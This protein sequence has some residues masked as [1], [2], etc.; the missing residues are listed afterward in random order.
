[1]AGARQET[2]GRQGAFSGPGWPVE[3]TDAGW[4]DMRQRRAA[5]NGGRSESALDAF[6]ARAADE[7]V[8]GVRIA[9]DSAA[10]LRERH[11]EP[12]GFDGTAALDALEGALDRLRLFVDDL[13]ELTAV[14]TAPLARTPLRAVV[15][16]RAAADGLAGPLAD[17]QVEVEIG[18]MPDLVAD[19]CLLERLFHHH[20][21]RGSLAA[22]GDGPGRIALSGVRRSAGVRIEVSDAGPPLDHATAGDLF[23]PFAVPR[24]AGPAAGAGVSMTIARRI[25]E[26]H[27]GSIWAHTGR[28]EGCTIVVLLPAAV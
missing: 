8:A 17:A 23:A 6:A 26:R 13:H 3:K 14:D 5:A 20:L 15:A 16:A 10:L 1:V 24:G 18:P 21:M 7:V 27:G 28:R 4:I 2:R 19:A 9:G 11:A 22:I 12:L 25:T